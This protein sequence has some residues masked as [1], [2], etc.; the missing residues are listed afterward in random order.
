[1]RRSKVKMKLPHRSGFRSDAEDAASKPGVE[2]TTNLA[3]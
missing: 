2:T 3:S 1:L